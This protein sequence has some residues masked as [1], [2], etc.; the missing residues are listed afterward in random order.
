MKEGDIVRIKF[1][2]EEETALDREFNSS[3]EGL[4]EIR[5]EWSDGNFDLFPAGKTTRNKLFLFKEGELELAEEQELCQSLN[6]VG[7]L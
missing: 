3:L 6:S 2:R 4:F 5:T 1:R 7:L